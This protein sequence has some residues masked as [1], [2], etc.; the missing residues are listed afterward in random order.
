MVELSMTKRLLLEIVSFLSLEGNWQE[1]SIFSGNVVEEF[2]VSKV[3][4]SVRS[5]SIFRIM[6][7]SHFTMPVSNLQIFKLTPEILSCLV[8]MIDP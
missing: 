5:L 7:L 8:V 2:T 4:R 1:Q 6:V 3:D